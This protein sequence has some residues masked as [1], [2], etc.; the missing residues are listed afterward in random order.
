M[1]LKAIVGVLFLLFVLPILLLTAWYSVSGLNIAN[2]VLLVLSYIQKAL[3]VLGIELGVNLAKVS[4]IKVPPGFVVEEIYEVPPSQGSWVAVTADDLGNLYAAD[5]INKGIY[6]VKP[7]KI[8]DGTAGTSVTRVNVPLKS[9]Q[10]LLWFNGSLYASHNSRDSGVWK[11]SDSDQDGLLDEQQKIFSA[12]N[13]GEHGLHGL[14]LDREEENL[15]LMAGNMIEIPDSIKQFTMPPNWGNDD[16]IPMIIDPSGLFEDT[17]V[18]GG[19]VA[20]I[21]LAEA[22]GPDDRDVTLLSV[23]FRN[24]YDLAMNTNGDI[25]TFD[26]DMEWDMGMPWYRPARLNHVVSGADYGWRNGS[27]K[28]PEYYADSLPATLNVGPASPTGVLFGYGSDFPR[29]WQEALYLLDWT[30]GTIWAATLT[31]SGS[32][33]TATIEP[34]TAATSLPVTDAV[35]GKDGAFYFAVGGRATPSKL[36]RITYSAE[37][38]D[39]EAIGAVKNHRVKNELVTLRNRLERLHGFGLGTD[40]ASLDFIWEHLSHTDRYVRHAALVAL[41]S[42]DT[43]GWLDRFATEEDPGKVIA[44]TIALSKLEGGAFSQVMRRLLEVEPGIE[45]EQRYLDWLRAISRTF[46]KHPEATQDERRLEVLQKLEQRFPTPRESVNRELVQILVF[47]DS[48]KIVPL[49]VDHMESIE[50]K[51]L[52]DWKS[53]DVLSQST[54]FFADYGGTAK[55]VYNNMPPVDSIH[56]ANALR[57]AKSGWTFDLRKRYFEFFTRAAQYPGGAS[58]RDFLREIRAQAA[59]STDESTRAALAELIDT[60]LDRELDFDISQP[61]GPGRNWT[62]AE[63]VAVATGINDSP[64][65]FEKGRSMYHAVGCAACH[66]F[67]GN[68]GAVGPDL[69][70]VANKFSVD[71]LL[72]SIINPA[73]VVSSQYQDATPMPPMLI[74]ALNEQEMLDLVA[75]MMSGGDPESAYYQR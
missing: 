1:R 14:I 53:I 29:K 21:P 48:S 22:E 43:E 64:R 58:Y 67:N 36:Y 15:L 63:A 7:S 55:A 71:Y 6:I 16:L 69:S 8:G 37:V 46:L 39:G 19:W 60:A 51:S 68:G 20:K 9:A 35:I 23:G 26:A 18:P 47:L 57:A 24:A 33:Y 42:Q 70:T 17:P 27:A 32:S 65:S 74:N 50:G 2:F 73:K 62:V 49:A 52:P 41:M 61:Q 38:N 59:E 66:Q 54:T 30:Y 75:Y 4:D 56:Y 5:Q 12:G 10:G 40:T 13:D 45:D 11:L 28:W 34:F 44:A 25:F 3:A 31:E 72:D